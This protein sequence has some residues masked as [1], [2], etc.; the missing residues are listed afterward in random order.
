VLW[1]RTVGPGPESMRILP[2][3]CL[4]LIW[5]GH[6]LFVAGPDSTARWHHSAGGASYVG[7]RFSGGT[8]PALLGLPA[9]EVLD[10]SPDLADVWPSRAARSLADRVAADPVPEMEA[11]AV[12]R[13]AT[14]DVNPIG[15]RVLSMAWG[16]T[17]VAAMADQL[18]LS[19]RHLHRRCLPVFGYGP[20][21]LA[22][23]LRLGRALDEARRG[24]PLARVAVDSG[25]VD[26]A[27]LN[28]EVRAL[29]GTTPTVLLRELR[30]R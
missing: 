14:R 6:R 2:D 7:L 8:G 16:Q 9:D 10:S 1:R 26:Q 24:L 23:V 28:R 21:R 25:Y 20:R 18:G 4:D 13:A 30:G 17:P 29:A 12:R 5:D 11:W 27:H 22:R 19:T 15:A 3:G